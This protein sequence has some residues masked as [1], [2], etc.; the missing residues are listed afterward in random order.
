MGFEDY[1][2]RL[3]L[4]DPND[5]VKFEDN[6]EMWQQSEAALRQALD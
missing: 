6:E 4:R 3:S 1:S 2:Y 5:K